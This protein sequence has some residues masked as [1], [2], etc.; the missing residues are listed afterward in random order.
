MKMSTEK[1]IIMIIIIIMAVVDGGYAPHVTNA[2]IARQR[3]AIEAF[4]L[5]HTFLFVT[6]DT[7]PG[8]HRQINANSEIIAGIFMG[9]PCFASD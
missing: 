4:R 2:W 5:N 1:N 6:A 3:T 8:L 9:N 7:V